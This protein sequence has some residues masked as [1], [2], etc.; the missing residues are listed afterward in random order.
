[1]ERK[2]VTVKFFDEIYCIINFEWIEGELVNLPPF[3]PTGGGIPVFGVV[4]H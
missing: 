1:M 2:E 4:K 3:Q